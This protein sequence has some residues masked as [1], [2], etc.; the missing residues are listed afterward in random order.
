MC[1]IL[2]F[3]LNMVLE[4][5]F[6]SILQNCYLSWHLESYASL[7]VLEKSKSLHRIADVGPKVLHCD[8]NLAIDNPTH[9][10]KIYIC[11]VLMLKSV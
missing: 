2:P 10:F 3:F 1:S 9:K 5:Q 11:S 4:H 7:K 6:K 8:S